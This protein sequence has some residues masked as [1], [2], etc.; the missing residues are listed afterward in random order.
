MSLYCFDTEVEKNVAKDRLIKDIS[1]LT[2]VKNNPM[3]FVEPEQ[4]EISYVGTGLNPC[5]INSLLEELGYI[6]ED[7]D[8]NGWQGDFW[9]TYTKENCYPLT[10]YYKAWDFNIKL[11]VVED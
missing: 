5:K 9:I 4:W 2:F 10:L 11:Y 7:I 6:R 8:E 1:H 3:T